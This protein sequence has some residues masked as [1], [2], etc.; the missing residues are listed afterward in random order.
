MENLHY[1]FVINPNSGKKNAPEIMDKINKLLT[2]KMRFDI[3]KWTTLQEFEKIA[4]TFITSGYTHVVAVGGDGSVNLTATHLLNKNIV[5]GIIPSGSGNGLARSLGIS[6]NTDEALLQLLKNRVDKIDVGCV[7]GKYFFCTS[8]TGF[9]AHI[10]KLFAGLK[11]RGLKMYIKLIVKEFFSYK[12]QQYKINIDGKEI[13]R[14]AFFITI[15]NAGQFG[16]DFYIAP[17]AILNDGLLNVVILKPF[18]LLNSVGILI[19]VLM[20]QAD[21]SRFIE[22]Y[23]GKN[24]II[25]RE[26]PDSVHFDGEPGMETEILQY[27]VFPNKIAVVTGKML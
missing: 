27:S 17:K 13:S 9:D 7:N 1:L 16:N 4:A 10:G 19:R 12:P 3:V 18:N 8:G 2:G 15:G 25:T 22:S 5:L 6:M 26:K 24:I 23:T 21:K 20:K 14:T 11:T